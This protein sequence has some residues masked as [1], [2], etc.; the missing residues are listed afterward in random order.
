MVN[1]SEK[2]KTL[3]VKNINLEISKLEKLIDDDI[4]LEAVRYFEQ[5]HYNYDNIN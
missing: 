2:D 1:T 4:M 3:L 5:R